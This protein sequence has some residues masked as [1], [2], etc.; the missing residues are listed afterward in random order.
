MDIWALGCILFEMYYGRH[1][2]LKEKETIT[3]RLINKE[4]IRDPEVHLF[5]P[6][7]TRKFSNHGD[8][9]DLIKKCLDKDYR[10][11]ATIQAVLD[12]PFLRRM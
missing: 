10:T 1:P 9:V 2:F 3:R 7:D 5:Y 4:A 12:H 11:R 8:V 6:E